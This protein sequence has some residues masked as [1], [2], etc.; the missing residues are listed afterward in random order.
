MTGGNLRVE[1]VFAMPER[2]AL[3]ELMVDPGAT[4]ADA[5]AASGLE[6]QFPDQ[7]IGSQ[8]VGIWGRLV[9]RET[10]LTDGD[11]V[12]IYRQLEID[13]KEARRR[14]AALGRTMKDPGV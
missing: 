8:P 9:T 7:R 4:V 12:E 1:V 10:R 13:P 14:L 11:R 2:Q 5:I 6:G 3:V